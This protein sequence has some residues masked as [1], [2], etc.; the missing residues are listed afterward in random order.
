MTVDR[1][2]P[3]NI[4]GETVPKCNISLW[5]IPFKCAPI[6]FCITGATSAWYCAFKKF[7]SVN[8]HCKQILGDSWICYGQTFLGLGLGKLFPARESLVSDIPA[9]DGKPL[10][11][12]YSVWEMN[13]E[14][15]IITDSDQIWWIKRLSTVFPLSNW[16]ALVQTTD[17]TL[18]RRM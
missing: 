9:R 10:N 12:F 3:S 5:D 15:Q 7:S 2:I 6:L 4:S 8:L 13:T 1:K 14:M 16:V 11:H 17:Q 18:E